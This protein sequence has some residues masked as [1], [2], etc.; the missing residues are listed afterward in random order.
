QRPRAEPWLVRQRTGDYDAD[1]AGG[2]PGGPVQHR[3]RDLVRRD[4]E[5][6]LSRSRHQLPCQLKLA[7]SW[8]ECVLFRHRDLGDHV[9]MASLN[10][11]IQAESRMR[12][13]L[14]ENGL[15]QPDAVE[16]GYTC[17]RLFFNEP[18]VMLVVD[19]DEPPPGWKYA[20]AED[21]PTLLED[22]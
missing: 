19:I 9:G 15:P 18:K 10:K 1:L 14:E 12:Q 22:P 11:K 5:E 21:D 7:R 16:Y 8:H 17:V 3:E 4:L 20:G 6:Q 13:L 2:R